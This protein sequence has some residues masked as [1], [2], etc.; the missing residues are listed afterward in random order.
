MDEKDEFELWLFKYHEEDV[1]EGVNDD[2]TISHAGFVFSHAVSSIDG[3]GKNAA[4]LMELG[5]REGD[6]IHSHWLARYGIVLP[7]LME[8][9]RIPERCITTLKVRPIE[10]QLILLD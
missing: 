2:S 4:I 9:R 6:V 1:T 8:N 3:G 7:H 5:E 10:E